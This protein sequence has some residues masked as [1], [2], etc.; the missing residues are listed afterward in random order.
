MVDD[1]LE[2]EGVPL[3]LK[4]FFY[5]GAHFAF[6]EALQGGTDPLGWA[7]DPGHLPSADPAAADALA[8]HYIRF[9]TKNSVIGS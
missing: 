3:V 4:A 5:A 6:C 9:Q 8:R 1:K 7:H 2:F